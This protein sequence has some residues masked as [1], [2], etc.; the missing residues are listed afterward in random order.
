M[1]SLKESYFVHLKITV[2]VLFCRF[3]D[4]SWNCKHQGCKNLTSSDK[5]WHTRHWCA[6]RWDY[7]SSN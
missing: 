6:W 7:F 2:G 1:N 4:H 3:E 5:F